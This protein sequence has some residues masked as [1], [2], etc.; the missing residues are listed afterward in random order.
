MDFGNSFFYKAKRPLIIAG[1]CSAES[2]SQLLNT[3]KSIAQ[4]GVASIFRAGIWKPRTQPGH[5]EGVGEKGISW[6]AKVKEETGLL[7][8]TEVATPYHAEKALEASID[9]VWIGARTTGNPIYVQEIANIL[10]N[11]NIKVMVKNPLHPDVDLWSGAIQR[12]YDSGI[13][14]IAAIHRGFYPYEKTAFR[15]LPLWEIPIALQLKH[16]NLPILCDPS[17]IAGKTSHIETIAQQ[18]MDINLSGLMIEV[19]ENPEKALTDKS[20]QINPSSL[21]ELLKHLEIRKDK[22]KDVTYQKKMDSYRRKIDQ[23]DF[24]LLDL[25]NQRQDIVKNIAVCKSHRNVNVLQLQRW[26]SILESRTKYSEELGLSRAYILKMLQLIHEEA[27]RIQTEIMST[28]Q[29]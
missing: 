23:I 5:F 11:T 3:A 10:R 22:F 17:H 6:L 26:E 12:F 19:H 8:A 27:I 18:A 25:L 14:D 16:K 28:K 4:T 20:Q 2:E 15:N 7:T 1:P 24:Q 29:A 9:I 13:R 21:V